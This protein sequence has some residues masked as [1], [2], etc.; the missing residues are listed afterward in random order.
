LVFAHRLFAAHQ[1]V[2]TEAAVHRD[3]EV[4]QIARRSR[5][6]ALQSVYAV[7]REHYAEEYTSIAI[8]QTRQRFKETILLAS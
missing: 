6:S 2:T 5:L 1:R 8:D 4:A 3:S 7:D